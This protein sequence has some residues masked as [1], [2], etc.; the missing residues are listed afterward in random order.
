MSFILN[1]T[2]GAE[3]PSRTFIWE[4]D[5]VPL[6]FVAEPH[7]FSLELKFPTP[8]T[9]N[10]GISGDANGVVT[11]SFAASETDDWPP[12]NHLGL[13]WAKRTA[14]NKDREPLRLTVKVL[15]P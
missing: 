9:K 12:G 14:D 1:I 11:I 13:L 6:D 3:L 4:V 8:V 5:D 7:T 10:S 2:P 15:T